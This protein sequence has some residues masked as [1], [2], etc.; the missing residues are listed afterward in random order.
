MEGEGRERSDGGEI[1][2]RRR[3]AERSD[4]AGRERY[5]TEREERHI[6]WR[7]RERPEVRS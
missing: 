5:Q 2:W 1:R 3:R 7:G 6:R 4:G